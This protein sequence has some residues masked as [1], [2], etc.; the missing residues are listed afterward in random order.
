MRHNAPVYGPTKAAASAPP[1]KCPLVPD[2]TG[3]FSIWAAKMNAATSPANGAARSFSSRCAPRTQ[4]PIPA[5]ATTP[6]ASDTGVLM[7]PSGTCTVPH[8][9]R[10][11]ALRV[12]RARFAD[13]FQQLRQICNTSYPNGQPPPPRLLNDRLPLLTGRSRTF[14]AAPECRETFRPGSDQ[15]RYLTTHRVPRNR[16]TARQFPSDARS[17]VWRPV[18]CDVFAGI[19]AEIGRTTSH[20]TAGDVPLTIDHQVLADV[21]PGWADGL[22]RS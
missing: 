14:G 17:L 9:L 18:Q 19:F 21:E 7:N 15:A 22:P 13:S 6:A 1:S 11:G 8:P 3:K 5:N 20:S 12:R 4:I 2:A 16:R 10:S